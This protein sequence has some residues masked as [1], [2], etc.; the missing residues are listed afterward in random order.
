MKSVEDDVFKH[1]NVKISATDLMN[2][3]VAATQKVN[4]P[5]ID[6]IEIIKSKGIKTCAL[7]NNWYFGSISGSNR[8]KSAEEFS[9]EIKFSE[10]ILYTLV[11][12]VVESRIVKMRKPD[13]RIY[14]YTI[15]KLGVDFKDCV[16]LD[17][18]GVNLKAA[19]K[20]G[21]RT[22]QVKLSDVEGAVEELE[23][24]LGFPLKKLS[25]KL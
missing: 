9:S 21:I 20:L 6:A 14:Q 25:S 7:T 8:Q 1:Y 13:P 5:I 23:K 15:E 4:Q 17:D 19:Q 18:L 11:D 16:F 12:V 10:S 24:I 2:D 3:I 22:V